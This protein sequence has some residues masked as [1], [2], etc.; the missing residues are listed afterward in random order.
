MESQK[1]FDQAEAKLLEKRAEYNDT[2]SGGYITESNGDTKVQKTNGTAA[3]GT[4]KNSD[5][6]KCKIRIKRI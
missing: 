6:E 4:S 1:A 3:S 2:I 5:N